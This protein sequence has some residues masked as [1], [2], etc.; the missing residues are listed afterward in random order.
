MLLGALLPTLLPLTVLVWQATCARCKGEGVLACGKHD[1]VPREEE[2]PTPENPVAYCSWAAACPD[3]R[4]TLWVD[5]SRCDSGRRSTAVEERGR[6]IRS[7]LETSP[8]AR[9]LER[10]VPRLETERFQLAVD[11]ADLPGE[12]R[13]KKKKLSGHEL[14][15]ELARDM[16]HVSARIREHYQLEPVDYRAKMRMW[17]WAD[18]ATHQKAQAAFQGTLTTGDFKVLGRD[19]VFSVWTE[20]PLFDTV[21][22]VR[23][24]FVHNAA[25]ML[26]SNVIQ[27]DWVGDIGGGWLDAGLGHWYEYELFGQTLNICLEESTLLENYENG[28]WRA[29]VRRRL[30]RE[31]EP[32]LPGLLPKRTGAMSAAEHAL[33]WSFYDYLLASRPGVVRKL[34]VDLKQKKPARESLPLHLGMD[35][36]TIDAAWRSWVSA[37]YPLKGDE[38]RSLMEKKGLD[39]KSPDRGKK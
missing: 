26:L 19:P 3:C 10:A 28:R 23:T 25:H 29:A 13:G 21:P 27:P 35:L 33:C 16:E 7:W 12:G 30:E 22:E 36:F 34:L 18:L 9:A 39:R 32:F 38:P 24:L 5:C 14:A 20:R 8:L 1:E 4:G 6:L 11:I 17:L 31:K 15:H 2:E 37:T